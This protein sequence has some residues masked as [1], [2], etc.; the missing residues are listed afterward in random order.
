VVLGGGILQHE[1]A[2]ESWIR[3]SNL[4]EKSLAGACVLWV[5][6]LLVWQIMPNIILIEQQNGNRSL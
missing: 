1:T 6:C 3:W 2:P 5:D 4:K